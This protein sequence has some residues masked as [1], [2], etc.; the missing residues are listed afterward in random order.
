MVLCNETIKQGIINYARNVIF[1]TAPTFVTVAAVRAGYEILT[2]DEGQKVRLSVP[3]KVGSNTNNGLKLQRRG[4][5]QQNIGYFYWTLTRHPRWEE[6]KQR[7]IL[8]LPTERIWDTG[9]FKSP[10]VPVITKAGQA[11]NLCKSLRRARF[12]VNSV[13]FPSVPKGTGRVRLMIHADN[14]QEEMDGVIHLIMKW[15]ADRAG[16]AQPVELMAKM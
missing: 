14:T 5:L 15:A 13:E 6:M 2:S 8:Y 7:G 12:W 1:T 11:G 9:P 4:R 16:P 10:I 3:A